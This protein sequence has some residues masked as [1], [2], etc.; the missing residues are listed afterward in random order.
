MIVWLGAPQ[1]K[2]PLYQVGGHKR[3]GI[4]EKSVATWYGKTT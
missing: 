1:G 3:S 4:G 2:S